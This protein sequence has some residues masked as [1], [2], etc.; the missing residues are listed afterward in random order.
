MEMCT[1]LVQEQKNK[2]VG[3][4]KFLCFNVGPPRNGGLIQNILALRQ[5]PF[6]A[7]THKSLQ[8][9][10]WQYQASFFVTWEM[11]SP[12]FTAGETKE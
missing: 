3:M 5:V 12:L 6:P 10:Q 7:M 11:A 4:L 8:G 1:S 9:L 2:C